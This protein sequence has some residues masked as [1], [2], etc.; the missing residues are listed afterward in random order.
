MHKLSFFK[1][2]GTIILSSAISIF[3][4]ILAITDPTPSRILCMF[5]MLVSTLGDYILSGY[6]PIVSRLPLK[7]FLAGGSVFAVAHIIYAFA[8]GYQIFTSTNVFFNFGAYLGLSILII[9]LIVITYF[10][11]KN[12]TTPKMTFFAFVYLVLICSNCTCV[13]SL[14]V[15]ARG[16]K[17]ISAIGV[18][19]FM[20]S[21]LII[22]LDVFGKITIQHRTALIW[23]I[24][25]LG[26]ILLLLGA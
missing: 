6:K 18:L 14:A 19:L 22:A 24:Y 26:Q 11:S 9:L 21:D 2:P 8:F 7:G 15:S 13:L 10:C 20:A 16:L 25:P 23:T 12:K 4:I 17:I 5:A 3:A 1:I